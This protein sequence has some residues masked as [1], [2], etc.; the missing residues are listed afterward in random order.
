[1]K[2]VVITGATGMVGRIVLRECLDSPNI[3]KITSFVRRPSGVNHPKL[4]EVIHANFMDYN[5][6]ADHFENIDVAYFC[7]GAYTGAVPDDK[8]KQITV[9][10]TTVFADVLK[11]KSPNATFCL[12]SGQGADQTEKSRVSFAK[13]KGM[14][15]NYLIQKDFGNLYIFRPAYIYPVEQREEPNLMYRVSRKLY[16]LLK[17][18]FPSSVITS[19]QLGKAIFKAGVQGAE[20]TVLENQDIKKI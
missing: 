13:Y 8:F 17:N 3:G 5:D 15:E 9:D 19:E 4:N 6:V 12:L 18:V 7:I 10:F 20:K 11:Q 16:P 2:N 14:A 1:M